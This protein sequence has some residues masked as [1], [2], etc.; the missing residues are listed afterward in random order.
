MFVNLCLLNSANES[1]WLSLE[2]RL[3]SDG[4]DSFG[5]LFAQSGR[6]GG[7]SAADKNKYD[8]C[9]HNPDIKHVVGFGGMSIWG[10]ISY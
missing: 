1:V 6:K 4:R 10:F 7:R 5:G 2:L 3:A 8:C 9:T